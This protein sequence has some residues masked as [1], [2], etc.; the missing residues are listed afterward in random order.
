MDWPNTWGIATS[1]MN[2]LLDDAKVRLSK[3]EVKTVPHVCKNIPTVSV[4]DNDKL[5]FQ[6]CEESND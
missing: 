2:A 5:L 3:S 4:D 6:V 1:E